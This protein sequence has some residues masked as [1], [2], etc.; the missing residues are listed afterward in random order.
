MSRYGEMQERNLLLKWFPTLTFIAVVALGTAIKL[1]FSTARFRLYPDAIAYVNIARNVASGEGFVSTLKVNYFIESDVRH[2]ALLDWPP[3]YPLFAGALAKI[4]VTEIGLQAVNAFLA[5]LA[6]GLVFL[7]ALRLFDAKSAALAGILGAL[8]LSLFKAGLTALSDP[9]GLVLALGAIATAISAGKRSGWWLVSGLLAG[10]AFAT[11]FPNGILLPALAW[12][13]ATRDKNLRSAVMVFIGFFTIIGPLG[14]WKWAILG[15]PISSVQIFHYTTDSF[16]R[17]AW[18]WHA[19]GVLRD[20]GFV[21][22][23]DA[24][25]H[26]TWYF[27]VNVLR[28]SAGL[29]FLSFGLAWLLIS[30]QRRVLSSEHKLTLSV[31]LLNFIVYALTPSLP[32]AQG[33]RFMLLTFC[34]LLPFCTAGL[35]RMMNTGQTVRKTVAVAICLGAV[36]VWIKGYLPSVRGATELPP[37]DGQIVRWAKASLQPGTVVASNNPW[38]IA[39][40]T[41]L[42]ACALPHNLDKKLMQMFI[43][44]NRVGA[45]I[46]IKSSRR[47]RTIESAKANLEH[48][49]SADLGCAWI[50]IPKATK[51]PTISENVHQTYIS[52]GKT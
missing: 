36:F 24:A 42:P 22:P 40:F 4:G 35:V 13:A 37:L 1:P 18:L 51:K 11:R 2:C 14:I 41:G 5:S 26:N 20:T 48:F 25:W 19:N 3:G 23:I 17:D 10:T 31:A 39:H 52:R 50:G 8:S 30:S 34:L 16:Q 27:A 32:S 21:F 12:F 28:T 45:I 38:L 47:S 9:L 29:Q 15:S 6:A 44:Q 7:I 49:T 33:N 43:E 46:V